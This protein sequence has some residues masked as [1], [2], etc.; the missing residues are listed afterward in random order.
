MKDFRELEDSLSPEGK[1]EAELAK[2]EVV[3]AMSLRQFRK[4]V[5][6]LTQGGLAKLMNVSQPE[7][8]KLESRRDML[9]STLHDYCAAV[10]AELHIVMEYGGVQV[11]LML[12]ETRLHEE[13]LRSGS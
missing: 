9:I 3:V 6:G 5:S 12:P 13:P 7:V 1:A 4:E 10:G 2:D 8:S 11:R